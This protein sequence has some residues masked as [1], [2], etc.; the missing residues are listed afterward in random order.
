M[1][2]DGDCAIVVERM[3]YAILDDVDFAVSRDGR[4]A[5]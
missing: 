4:R 5:P 2:A 3:Q 1:L